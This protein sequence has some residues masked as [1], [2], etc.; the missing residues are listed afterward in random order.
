MRAV[1]ELRFVHDTSVSQ[2]LHLSELIDRAVEQDRR[3]ERAVSD[4]GDD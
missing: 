4:E 2:G 1:P 3:R